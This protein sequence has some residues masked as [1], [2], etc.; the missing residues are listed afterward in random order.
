MVR[1]SRMG[2]QFV[3]M[4]ALFFLL[5]AVPALANGPVTIHPFAGDPAKVEVG[6]A[7]SLIHI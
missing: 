1:A 5:C 7:L 6:Y 2:I 4:N 3:S